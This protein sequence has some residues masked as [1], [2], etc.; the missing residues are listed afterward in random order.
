MV[1]HIMGVVT[2]INLKESIMKKIEFI[3]M[4]LTM[5]LVSFS[6]DVESPSPQQQDEPEIENF[7]T[8]TFSSNGVDIKG[9]ELIQTTENTISE[10]AYEVGFNDPAWFSRAFKEEFG[11]APSAI[12]K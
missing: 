4:I 5:A 10:I 2:S 8:F 6:K 12:S 9:K 7:T 11:F 1:L 3:L